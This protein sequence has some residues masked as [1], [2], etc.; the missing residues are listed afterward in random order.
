MSTSLTGRPA[1]PLCGLA[2]Q[3]TAAGR[4]LLPGLLC[5]CA[6]AAALQVL[7]G[8]AS[9]TA[10]LFTVNVTLVVAYAYVLALRGELFILSAREAKRFAILALA[11]AV[12]M[13]L[14]P[15]GVHAGLAGLIVVLVPIAAIAFAPILWPRLNLIQVS[16]CALCAMILPLTPLAGSSEISLFTSARLGLANLGILGLAAALASS[17]A[18][19]GRVQ[20]RRAAAQ[21][22]APQ[23]NNLA[24]LSS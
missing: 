19:A 22:A 15:T 9:I 2:G 6:F 12:P 7:P 1:R 8:D 18:L 23:L 11:G 4:L 3:R 5:A 10:L 20:N 24:S 14:G 17:Y 16:F 13:I 21:Q